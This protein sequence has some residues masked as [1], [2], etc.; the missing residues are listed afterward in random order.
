MYNDTPTIAY[1]HSFEKEKQLCPVYSLFKDVISIKMYYEYRAS[2]R[3][4]TIF[5]QYFSRK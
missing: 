5:S 3:H 1:S 2:K 4:F